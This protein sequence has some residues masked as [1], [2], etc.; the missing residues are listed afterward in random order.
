[1]ATESVVEGSPEM[2]GP[3]ALGHYDSSVYLAWLRAIGDLM[4]NAS[5][6]PL[7]GHATSNLGGLVLALS[8]AAQELAE[9]DRAELIARAKT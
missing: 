6:D 1:M 7:P 9:Q 8:E 4:M 5:R 2:F 3:K